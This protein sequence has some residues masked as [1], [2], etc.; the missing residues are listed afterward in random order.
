MLL[1]AGCSKSKHPKAKVIFGNGKHRIKR[2]PGASAV[3]QPMVMYRKSMDLPAVS[4]PH[5]P[6]TLPVTNIQNENV[7]LFK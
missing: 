6:I 4:I 7:I 2:L 5:N 1:S 3:A